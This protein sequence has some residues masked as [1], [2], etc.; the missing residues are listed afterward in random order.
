MCVF[1]HV[2]IHV[3]HN[4]S[5]IHLCVIGVPCV[6]SVTHCVKQRL[7]AEM[8]QGARQ[9]GNNSC[10]WKNRRAMMRINCTR[11]NKS[12]PAKVV[13]VSLCMK[14]SGNQARLVVNNV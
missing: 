12:G 8:E 10:C 6:S 13:N 9:T 2:K 1:N 7:C 3:S 4:T 11:G 5:Q 14:V